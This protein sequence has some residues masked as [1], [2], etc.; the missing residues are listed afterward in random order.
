MTRHDLEAM[1]REA[2]ASALLERWD[3]EERTRH[4]PFRSMVA[5]HQRGL[6]EHRWRRV[7]SIFATGFLAGLAAGWM[8]FGV[9]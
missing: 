3:L 9:L 2:S 8:L 7:G 4:A 6:A 1:A 5:A